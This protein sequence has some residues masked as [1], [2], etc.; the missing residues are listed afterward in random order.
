MEKQFLKIFKQAMHKLNLVGVKLL[1]QR[2]NK[3]GRKY[4]DFLGKFEFV[5][6]LFFFKDELI[7][8]LMSDKDSILEYLKEFEEEQSNCITHKFTKKIIIND[9]MQKKLTFSYVFN[10]I[11]KNIVDF[12]FTDEKMVIIVKGSGM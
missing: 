12:Y 10:I 11:P 6:P 2:E 9:K 8:N 1:G 3:Q 4:Y 5:P 7:K